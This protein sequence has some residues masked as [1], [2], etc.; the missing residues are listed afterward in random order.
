VLEKEVGLLT[1]E[2]DGLLTDEELEGLFTGESGDCE[3]RRLVAA[4]NQ[5]G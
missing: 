4:T 3:S 1:S 2:E 5:E